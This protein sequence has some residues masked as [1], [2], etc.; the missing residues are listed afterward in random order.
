MKRLIVAGTIFT[1]SMTAGAQLGSW[2][3][4]GK[5]GFGTDLY[6][7]DVKHE[8]DGMVSFKSSTSKTD[9]TLLAF[10]TRFDCVEGAFQTKKDGQWGAW[11]VI[12]R[13]SAAEVQ[14]KILC[15]GGD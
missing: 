2:E 13:K 14:A 10:E 5:S 3:L 4:A 8:R 15:K 12:P 7:K 9:G 6:I 1:I 11:K